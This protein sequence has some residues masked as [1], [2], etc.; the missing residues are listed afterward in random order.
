MNNYITKIAFVALALN[1]V[2]CQSDVPDLQSDIAHNQ[3]TRF[4]SR[5]SSENYFP[6]G[7][8][9]FRTHEEKVA[10]LQL[11]EDLLKSIS[12]EELVEVCMNYPLA[13][14]CFAFNSIEY[15][16]QKVISNFN[17]FAELK[18]RDNAFNKVLEFYN[19]K[20]DEIELL[21]RSVG[22]EINSLELAFWEYFI[23]S[24]YLCSKN[25]LSESAY[26]KDLIQKSY[27]LKQ[28]FEDLSG[29]VS[30]S[31]LKQLS[32]KS[33]FHKQ[34]RTHT[35]DDVS[36][37]TV[38][39]LKGLPVEALSIKCNNPSGDK[40]AG[41][42]YI[43]SKYP[44]ATILADAS[45]TYNCHAYAWY[46]AEGGKKCWINNTLLDGTKNVSKF[47]SDGTYKETKKKYAQ[48]AF[49][50]SDDHS[51]LVEFSGNS[52]V[53]KWGQLPLVQ[54]LWYDSPYDDSEIR[55]FTKDFS[56]PAPGEP[57]PEPEP[58]PV[59]DDPAFKTGT[60]NWDMNPD[61]TPVNSYED[62]SISDI[63]DTQYYR[64]DVFVSTA[65]DPSEP[66]TD[67]SLAYI[68][69]SNNR[70]ATAYFA[71]RG[72]YHVCFYV[73]S[74]TTGKCIAEYTSCEIYVAPP[75]VKVKRNKQG[76]IEL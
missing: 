39:T 11:P 26:L 64:V 58:D 18:S 51:A 53:A 4:I 40:K 50:V 48:K 38:Y 36:I 68:V 60:V 13:L 25:E 14:D 49:Y 21:G 75:T 3:A 44:N 32:T 24:E 27:S 16:M 6:D 72:I 23:S 43:K 54:H 12:T 74:K 61:P 7:W 1:S 73:Y 45:C 10:A 59:P 52:F 8:Q 62:F 76:E 9:N 17:G 66:I 28:S 5:S 31:S 34:S 67:T 47:Y 71:A 20:L 65:K 46:I 63:Y 2:S 29:D 37:I 57:D 55:Y 19:R 30:A 33:G 69:S 70:T 35:D 22:Y 42:N 15:G 41:E 56:S